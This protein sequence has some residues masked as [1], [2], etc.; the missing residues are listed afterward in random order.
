M[1]AWTAAAASSVDGCHEGTISN[2]ARTACVDCP[3]GYWRPGGDAAPDSNSCLRTP[4]GWRT[5]TATAASEV[6]LCDSGTI[7][8]WTDSDS[9]PFLGSKG[10]STGT[11]VP[12]DPTLCT[13]CQNN[14]FVAMDGSSDCQTCRAGYYP[15]TTSIPAGENITWTPPVTQLQTNCAPCPTL[16]YKD[17][18]NTTPYCVKCPPGSETLFSL[19][20]SSCTQ[21]VPG[22]VNPSQT[23]PAGPLSPSAGSATYYGAAPAAGLGVSTSCLPW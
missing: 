4:S 1:G 22:Y 21:C 12:S 6:A 5:L 3:P 11:R 13:A 15:S 17:L 9:T 2:P 23:D 20:A 19:G 16:Y 14:T 7:S 18:S 10:E 8:T